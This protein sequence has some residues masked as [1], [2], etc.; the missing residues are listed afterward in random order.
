MLYDINISID[1]IQELQEVV[2]SRGTSQDR[3]AVSNILN[4]LHQMQAAAEEAEELEFQ[5]EYGEE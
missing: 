3:T 4:T 2:E 1:Q 5:L